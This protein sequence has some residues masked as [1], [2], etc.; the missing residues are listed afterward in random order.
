MAAAAPP[1]PLY[2]LVQEG[3][4]AEA[5]A[6]AR[7][8]VP[9]TY[10]ADG[11]VHLTA[12]PALLLGVANHFYQA[13]PGAFLLLELDPARLAGEVRRPSA[14]ARALRGPSASA[15][16]APGAP[17]MPDG[18]HTRP[19]R[20][21]PAPHRSSS[22]RRRRSARRRPRAPTRAR[23]SPT[24]TAPSSRRPCFASC[25]CRAGR[26]AS[27]WASRGSSRLAAA[28]AAAPAANASRSPV[29]GP[30][31]RFPFFWAPQPSN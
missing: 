12:E 27:F 4:W 10:E 17:P 23:C 13:V 20:R 26:A 16:H 31:Q 14:R 9:P 15:G 28:A 2:H 24:C 29:A 18:A 25:P 30:L 1:G 8:Y 7:P 22:S 19:T 3:L 6:A 21:P 5:R 11:F